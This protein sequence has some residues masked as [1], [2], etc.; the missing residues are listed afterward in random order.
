MKK[1]FLLLLLL[2][3]VL[4]ADF[5]HITPAQTQEMIDKGVVLIDI[6]RPEEWRQTGI[7]PTSHRLTFFDA[8]GGY[9]VAKWMGAFEKIVTDKNQPF[10]LVCRTANRTKAVGDFLARKLGYTHV[11]DL[12]GGIVL[13]KKEKREVEAVK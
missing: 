13:W 5:N 3:N 10:V 1:T 11:N 4:L 12:E 8:R 9:N 7:V 6:R 2:S